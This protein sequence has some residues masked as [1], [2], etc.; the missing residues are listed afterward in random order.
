MAMPEK[1]QPT[2]DPRF[3]NPAPRPAFRPLFKGDAVAVFD[4]QCPGCDGPRHA[5]EYNDAYEVVVVR[6]GAFVR[7][8]NGS[9]AFITAGTLMFA[10]AG[11]V[12]RISHPVPGG[13][14]CSVF[15]GSVETLRE[16]LGELE[17]GER[18]RDEPRFP[19][20]HAAIGGRE[21]L[22]HRLAMRAAV[23]GAD[24][25]EQE[26]SAL[27]FLSAALAF[28]RA[29]H[30]RGHAHAPWLGRA[31]WRR[32]LERAA[33]VED[34]IRRSYATPLTLAEIG[35]GVGC[36]PFHLSR[37]VRAVTGLSIHGVLVRYRLRHALELVLD[38]RASLSDVA[39]S[40]GFSSHSHLSD[41]FRRQF[42]CSP[43]QARRRSSAQIR[44]ML[45][46]SSTTDQGGPA[47]CA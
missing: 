26:E 20:R 30:H 40:T 6:H 32:A 38:S 18:E 31:A 1:M 37:A 8:V 39:Y 24:L 10:T 46:R 13:D 29:R 42:G 4:W 12:H 33:G 34:V 35:R 47:P 41:T 27:C 44:T 25:V 5:E 36:S 2:A 7:E 11:E 3:Q 9:P 43:D 23:A 28:A 19:L 16:M 17:P 21:Y 22:L 45:R 14:A 15:R